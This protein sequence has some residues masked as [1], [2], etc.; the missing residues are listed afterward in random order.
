MN[1]GAFCELGN[2]MKRKPILFAIALLLVVGTALWGVNYRLDHPPLTKADEEFRVLVA[3]AD[4]VEVGQTSCSPQQA[5]LSA[6]WLSYGALNAEHTRKIISQ[7]RLE[8]AVPNRNFEGRPVYLRLTFTHIGQPL[9]ACELGQSPTL[10]L[11][12]PEKGERY[13]S[14]SPR[15]HKR[16]NRTLDAYLPQ[17]IRP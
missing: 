3:G 11:I 15:S 9:L 14:L 5:C 10:S 8:D 12:F 1:V 16:L 17:R 7:I 2:P 13:Y 4:S 6:T